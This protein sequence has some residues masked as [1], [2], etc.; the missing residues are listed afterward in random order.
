[1]YDAVPGLFSNRALYHKFIK[2]DLR[3]P[4]KDYNQNKNPER[5]ALKEILGNYPEDEVGTPART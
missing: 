4:I 3:I 5:S 1:M 2:A